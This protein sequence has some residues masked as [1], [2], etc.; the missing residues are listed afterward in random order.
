MR[1]HLSLLLTGLLA[2]PLYSLVALAHTTPVP[3]PVQ[4]QVQQVTVGATR[5]PVDKSYRKLLQGLDRFERDHALAPQALL[6]FRLLP[7]QPGVDMTGVQLRIAGDSIS[8]ALPL[9]EDNSFAPVRNAQAARK[10]AVLIAN[11]KATSMSWRAQ[12]ITPGLPPGTRRLGD[13]RLECRVGM[14]SG[15]ISN[16]PQI[17]AWLSSMLY[18][19]DKV[20]SEADGNYLFFTQ[21]PLFGVTLVHGER[22]V[23]L[24]F[25]MLYAGGEQTPA[26][27]PY[28]DCQV[29]L[30]HT[31]YAPLWDNSWPDDT[32]LEFT[33]M[34]EVA[35]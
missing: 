23:S 16:D 18:S 11:R 30:E 6:R 12:V 9:A 2:G 26:S 29:L 25:T 13:L 17:I 4:V 20:C 10:D 14:D 31:Y 35:P 15:L 34:D 8:I 21:R 33:Y 27:L 1:I 5:D 3:M 32:V 22:R 7:R 24:P 19:T 28:C